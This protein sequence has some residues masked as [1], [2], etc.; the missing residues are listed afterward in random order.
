M[1]PKFRGK[2][3]DEKNKG[4]WVYGNL[5][6]DGEKA[7]IVN[8]IVCCGEDYITLEDWCPV[9]LNTVG[10]YT[11]QK[12]LIGNEIFEGD[13]ISWEYWDEFTDRGKAQVVNEESSW[14]LLDVK[15][16]KEVWDSFSDCVSNCTVLI[17]SNIYKK[18]KI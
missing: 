5:I 14:K 7:V 6:I 15:T 9:D 17:E 16:G 8:G 12:D 2:S 10:Q 18:S 11:N 13:I 1:T 4:Q 3:I